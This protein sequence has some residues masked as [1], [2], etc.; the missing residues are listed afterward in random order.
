[1]TTDSKVVLITGAS[2]GIGAATAHRLAADGHRVV[3]G[4]RRMDKL[5]EVAEKIRAHS[6][7]ADH[8][9]LDVTSPD[10]VRDFVRG[11]IERH[12]RIDVLVNNAGIMPLSR[13]DTGRVEEWNQMIDVNMRGVLNGIAAVLPIMTAQ[14]SGHVVNVSST[15][16]IDVIPTSAVYSATKAA[17]RVLSEGLRREHQEIRVSVI[18]PSFTESE[19]ITNGGDPDTMAY[20]RK[21]AQDLNMPT[22]IVADAIAYAIDQPNQI[23]VN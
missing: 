1:M 17:V 9:P 4:A 20:V 12:G 23:D 13:L 3:L 18:S 10:S 6:G 16:G 21:L 11:A 14:G 15:L 7:T 19:L 5:A 22:S 8:L 2:S